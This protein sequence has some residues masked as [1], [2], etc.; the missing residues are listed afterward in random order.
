MVFIP[1]NENFRD[2][3]PTRTIFHLQIHDAGMGCAVAVDESHSQ[4]RQAEPVA[5]PR[6][7]GLHGVKNEDVGGLWRVA[8]VEDF[9][10]GI[11]RIPLHIEPGINHVRKVDGLDD[12]RH[13]SADREYLAFGGTAHLVVERVLAWLVCAEG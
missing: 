4:V 8:I 5:A 10:I 1:L 12:Q 11:L 6:L 13:R 7:D 9:I 2:L 3:Q